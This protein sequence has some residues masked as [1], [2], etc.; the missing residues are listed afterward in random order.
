MLILDILGEILSYADD[1]VLLFS[2][3]SWEE[4]KSKSENGLH[5]VKITNNKEC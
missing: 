1:T 4:V 3:V 2:D 5:K